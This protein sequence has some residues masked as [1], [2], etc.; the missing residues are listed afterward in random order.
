MRRKL[1]L[2]S[3]RMGSVCAELPCLKVRHFPLTSFPTANLHKIRALRF[4]LGPA[5]LVETQL[6]PECVIIDQASF[7]HLRGQAWVSERVDLRCLKE[8][9]F[10]DNADVACEDWP[11]A[12]RA[13]TFGKLFN[14]PLNIGLAGISR[15]SLGFR[16]NQ[17]LAS[18][19]PETLTFL[20]IVGDFDQPLGQLPRGLRTLIIGGEFNQNIAPGDL[21]DCLAVLRLLTPKLTP[22]IQ[23]EALPCALIR[24]QLHGDNPL[25]R[26]PSDI[27]TLVL[28]H[29]FNFPIAPGYLPNSLRSLVLPQHYARPLREINLPDS[30]AK[31]TFVEYNV[32]L[33]PG[34]LPPGLRYLDLGERYSYEMLPGVLPLSLEILKV[35]PEYNTPLAP[36]TL[37]ESLQRLEFKSYNLRNIPPGTLPSQCRAFFPRDLM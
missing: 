26:L 33:T 10:D 3:R 9:T 20:K 1:L 17:P 5:N 34:D 6:Q 32:P 19:L 8:L 7:I 37:P 16:F 4:P 14:R 23:A 27:E 13:L 12:L 28:D 35:S 29:R 30:L 22:A 18:Q 24:L 36:G 2:L 31:L 11:P 25:P 21:P 15:L